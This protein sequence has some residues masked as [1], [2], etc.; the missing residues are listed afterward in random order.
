MLLMRSWQSAALQLNAWQ[1]MLKQVRSYVKSAGCLSTAH[2]VIHPHHPIPAG[3]ADGYFNITGRRSKL[4]AIAEAFAAAVIG[5]VENVASAARTTASN[6]VSHSSMPRPV[7]QVFSG[8]LPESIVANREPY[9]QGDWRREPYIPRLGARVGDTL[10]Q[11]HL[12]HNISS[13]LLQAIAFHTT[14]DK[15][16]I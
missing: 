15:V 13:L 2:K 5:A 14:C 7:R 10:L 1:V 6:S 12:T 3:T 9:M 16:A 11:G 4:L 8:A